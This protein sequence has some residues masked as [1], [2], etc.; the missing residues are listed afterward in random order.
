MKMPEIS[1]LKTTILILLIVLIITVVISQLGFKIEQQQKLYNRSELAKLDA[2]LRELGVETCII[3][4]VDYNRVNFIVM[5]SFWEKNNQDILDRMGKIK[6]T[7]NDYA[8]RSDDDVVSPVIEYYDSDGFILEDTLKALVQTEIDETQ[9]EYFDVIVRFKRELMDRLNQNFINYIEQTN[10]HTKIIADV[11]YDVI[12][13]AYNP[14]RL[15]FYARFNNANTEQL[16]AVRIQYKRISGFNELRGD[17]IHF[18]NLNNSEYAVVERLARIM[19]ETK[20]TRTAALR[21]RTVFYDPLKITGK[22]WRDKLLNS[23]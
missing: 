8:K 22:G 21:N 13:D 18:Y 10:Y 11:K 14:K 15:F 5:L 7:I 3:Q 19:G 23:N 12:L 16:K 20:R 1:K 17:V 2:G 4:P 6:T 9:P